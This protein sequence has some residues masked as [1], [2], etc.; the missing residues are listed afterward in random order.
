MKS[1]R[2]NDTSD[3]ESARRGFL[4]VLP[5][6]FA[7]VVGGMVY[8]VAQLV[9]HPLNAITQPAGTVAVSTIDRLTEKVL[10]ASE[11]HGPFIVLVQRT[12][13]SFAYVYVEDAL[14][15]NGAYAGDVTIRYTNGE[16]GIVQD[17]GGAFRFFLTKRGVAESVRILEPL[18]MGIKLPDSKILLAQFTDGHIVNEQMVG[19]FGVI[20]VLE[21]MQIAGNRTA[22]GGV[23][24]ISISPTLKSIDTGLVMIERELLKMALAGAGET[25]SVLG[26]TTGNDDSGTVNL[27]IL[28]SNF[29]T[30]M[31]IQRFDGEGVVR[32][33][34]GG[35]NIDNTITNIQN[36]NPSFET[37]TY[38]QSPQLVSDQVFSQGGFFPSSFSSVLGTSGATG[39]TGVT[40]TQ[41]IKGDSGSAG[42]NGSNGPTG[43]TGTGSSGA[44]GELGPIGPTGATGSGSG[45]GGGGSDGPTGATGATGV[46]GPT[47]STGATGSQGS[48]GPTGSTGATGS[49]GGV[50]ASGPTGST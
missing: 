6:L 9:R 27:P 44:T 42:S 40:G 30:S 41:G 35:N 50:G 19:Q 12:D 2:A 45:G 34:T 23:L 46:Q 4:A 11:W 31:M 13:G 8:A 38:S 36:L 47:G 26:I 21:K 39:A 10:A 17:E 14:L 37:S 18:I 20:T 25:S 33:V 29:G 43:A 49:A 1:Q 28:S 5:L 48:S 7:V 32:I 3:Q 15:K 22:Q 24:S 16:H